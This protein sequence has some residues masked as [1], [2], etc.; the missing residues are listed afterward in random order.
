[1]KFIQISD[2][3]IGKR[4]Y[5]FDLEEDQRY[6]LGVIMD[7]IHQEDPDAVLIAGDIYDRA[8]PSATSVRIF[9]DFLSML[10]ITGKQIFIIYGNH[11][12]ASRIAYGSRVLSNAGIH[13]SPVYDGSI[14]PVTLQDEYGPV[15]FYMLPYLRSQDAVEALQ[16]IEVNEKERNIIISHQ[17]VTSAKLSESEDMN[18]GTLDNIDGSLYSKFDYAALGHIHMPQSIGSDGYEEGTT[19]RYSGS[20]LAYSFS[21]SD[22]IL[23]TV[24]IVKIRKKGEPPLL[25]EIGLLPLRRMSTI[26]GKFDDIL[27]NEEIIQKHKGDFIRVVLEDDMPIMDAMAKIQKVYPYVM[28]LEYE[29]MRQQDEDITVEETDTEGTPEELFCALYREQHD[30]KDPAEY[31][32]KK[33]SELI[34]EIW[35]GDHETD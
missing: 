16:K 13:I 5:G 4:L 28:T 26:K 19:I 22:R 15:N 3:H 20:P 12:S 35:E 25:H 24:S 7:I 33:I 10:A 17:F 9:D 18:V 31:Q 6:I 27:S 30:G 23:K 32:M 14:E 34:A 1:M 8:D 11:D 21:D 29:Y 2:L